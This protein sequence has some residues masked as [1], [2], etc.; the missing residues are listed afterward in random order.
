[1]SSQSPLEIWS[2]AWICSLRLW[3]SCESEQ[4]TTCWF[5]Y[6]VS[7]GS[8]LSLH[9]FPCSMPFFDL[10][11]GCWDS[12]DGWGSCPECAQQG[13]KEGLS[14]GTCLSWC[15]FPF[16]CRLFT[17]PCFC[18]YCSLCSNS[19]CD[20]IS[21]SSVPQ[22]FLSYCMKLWVPWLA[23]TIFVKVLHYDSQ[24]RK[25]ALPKAV[26]PQFIGLPF[27]CFCYHWSLPSG[28]WLCHHISF[29]FFKCVKES[30]CFVFIFAH[31]PV[32]YAGTM[33]CQENCI[34]VATFHCLFGW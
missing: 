33:S 34:P 31:S 16:L 25:S 5:S 2:L 7:S 18:P 14:V 3:I 17:R 32:S 23:G 22:G 8:L 9:G 20:V 13:K 1:M 6:A 26:I 28:L 10:P 12:F 24:L 11:V 4:R 21:L 15:I 30:C 29:H 27:I 19:V